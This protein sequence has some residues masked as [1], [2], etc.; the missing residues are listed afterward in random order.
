MREPDLD[1]WRKLDHMIILIKQDRLRKWVLATEDSK[2]LLLY[3]DCAFGVHSDYRSHTGGGLTMGKGF[4]VTVSKAHRLNVRSLTEGEIVSVDNCLSLVLW[5]RKFMSA[6]GYGCNRVIIL[7]D[8]KSSI[9]LENNGKASSGKRTQHMN[10][11]FFI[12]KDR[13]EKEEVKIMWVP[14][15]YMVADYLTKALQGA[16]FCCFRDLIMGSV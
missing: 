13:V 15:E 16:E 3:V 11:R 12:I 6:Q 8:N 5:S 1:D 9:L 10:I 7:Q 14:R 2:D 4:A